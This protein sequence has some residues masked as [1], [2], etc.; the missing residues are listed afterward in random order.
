MTYIELIAYF[1]AYGNVRF[2]IIASKVVFNN[3]SIDGFEY[4]YNFYNGKANRITRANK[5]IMLTLK[6]SIEDNKVKIVEL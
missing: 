4:Q 2:E 6:K 1:R 3:S 5:N